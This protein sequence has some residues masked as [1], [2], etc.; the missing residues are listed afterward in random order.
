MWLVWSEHAGEYT[1]PF[2]LAYCTCRSASSLPKLEPSMV[3]SRPPSVGS[4]VL[5]GETALT[6]GEP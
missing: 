1:T 6:S 4:G 5:S 3:T 2:S